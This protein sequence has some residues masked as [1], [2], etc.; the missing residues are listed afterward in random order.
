MYVEAGPSGGGGGGG[1][2]MLPEASSSVL[3]GIKVGNGLAIASGVLSAA[4]EDL[5]LRS[6][7][8]PAAPTSVTASG[9]NAEAAVSWSAPSNTLVPI[10]DYVVQFQPSGGAWQP[11]ADSVSTATTAIVTGL[12]NGIAYQFRVAAVTLLGQGDFSTPSSSVTP[13]SSVFR[14]IPAMTSNTAPSGVVTGV[15]NRGGDDDAWKAFDGS[16]ASGSW[17]YLARAGS[18]NPMRTLQYAFPDGEKS[19]ISG[20]SISLDFP[21]D[22]SSIP[23]QWGFYGS[24]DLANWTQIET[25]TDSVRSPGT[26]FETGITA[27]QSRT[28]T[29]S[30]AVNYRAYRWVFEETDAGQAESV[31]IREISLVQ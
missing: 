16:S 3:G 13:T 28:F 15:T 6:L 31:G 25:R 19:R 23:Y 7:L 20:Y 10:T 9:G 30:A 24:D 11:F 27:G 1:S 18:N 21:A 29:L 17:V 26:W 14:A 22:L 2:Y 4:A 5:L 8:R 12:Q